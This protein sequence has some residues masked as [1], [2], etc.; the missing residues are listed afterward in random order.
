MGRLGKNLSGVSVPRA[1][2]QDVVI[3]L[4]PRGGSGDVA[5]LRVT[6]GPA[7]PGPSIWCG[8]VSG[9]LTS[10]ANQLGPL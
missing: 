1:F 5:Q 8:A 2:A 9:P 7:G 10:A 3:V 4:T 6:D